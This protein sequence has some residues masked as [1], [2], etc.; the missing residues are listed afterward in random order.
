MDAEPTARPLGP[1]ARILRNSGWLLSSKGVGAV[2]SLVY[3]GLATRSLGMTGF[4]QF[5]LVLGAAQTVVAL[6]GFQTWQIVVRFGM[7]PLAAGDK[8]ALDDLFRLALALDLAG[9][10]IGCLIVALGMD[11]FGDYFGWSDTLQR[12][13]L[14]FAMVMLLSFRSTPV[15]VLRLHDRFGQGALADT[16]TPIVRLIGALIVV[17]AGPS[18]SGFL[19]VWAVAEV[20]TSA[21]TWAL[22]H[23]YQR[24]SLGGWR[25]SSLRAVAR[26][27]SGLTRFAAITNL[28]YSLNGLS[29][30]LPAVIVGF[31]VGTIAAGQFRLVQQLAL[32]LAKFGDLVA[33]A[34]FAEISRVHAGA[35]PEK[36]ARLFR[37]ALRLSAVAGAIVVVVV[38]VAGKPLLGLIA[39][40]AFVPAYP[41]L[42]LMGLA[43]A[44]NL[45]GV[46]FEP[47]LMATG[48]AGTALRMRIVTTAVLLT[49]VALLLPPFGVIGAGGATIA[50]AVTGLVLLGSAAWR[51]V[52][53]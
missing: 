5:T 35:T 3:L 36:L 9:A 18:V 41:L 6:V 45:A 24:I 46:G 7:A 1:L 11:A 12:H 2:L 33:R 44:I 4:G 13:A 29:R 47:T 51:A 39:G 37:K 22:A 43:A 40:P 25:W 32:G 17:W 34:M 30:Q 42:I 20:V 38:I 28:G 31:F 15:G 48:G 8:G 49:L 19:L 53:R 50:A 52:H 10:L 21:A 16:L 27:H 23:R 14:V 26:R